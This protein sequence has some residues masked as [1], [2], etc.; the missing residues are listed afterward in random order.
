MNNA[1]HGREAWRNVKQ[2]CRVWNQ[3]LTLIAAAIAKANRL[4]QLPRRIRRLL[5]ADHPTR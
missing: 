3:R 4:I 5:P 1:F 2:H